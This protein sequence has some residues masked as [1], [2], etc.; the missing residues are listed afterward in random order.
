M[1]RFGAASLCI[2]FCAG[3]G[4]QKPTHQEMTPLRHFQKTSTFVIGLSIL[5]YDSDTDFIRINNQ[6]TCIG[7]G[8]LA[9]CK[10]TDWIWVGISAINSDHAVDW[11][12]HYTLV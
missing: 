8:W 4:P 3:I 5:I 2:I 9:G 10:E 7:T 6:F 11:P 12:Y 1:I